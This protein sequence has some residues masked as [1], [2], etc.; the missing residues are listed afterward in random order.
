[1]E[2]RG[3][4]LEAVLRVVLAWVFLGACISAEL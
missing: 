1:M 4:I 3:G 2:G